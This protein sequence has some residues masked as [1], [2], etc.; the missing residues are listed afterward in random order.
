MNAVHPVEI[1]VFVAIAIWGQHMP[2]DFMIRVFCC[3]GT[4]L[5]PWLPCG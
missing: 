2:S 1:K 3:Y 5:Y 4:V